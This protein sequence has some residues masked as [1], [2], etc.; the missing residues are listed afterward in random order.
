[1]ASVQKRGANSWLL[2]VEVGIEANGKRIK[3]TK[4]VKANGIREARKLLAEFQT[5]VEAGE[6]VAP[7]KMTLKEFTVNEWQPKYA[8]KKLS[9]TTRRN[10]LDQLNRRILPE[11]GHMRLDQIKTMHLVT[12]FN[13]L[14]EPGSRMD[15]RGDVLSESAVLYIYKV[16]KNVLSR[17]KQWGIILKSPI[18]GVDKPTMENTLRMKRKRKFYDSEEAREIILALL[19]EP[20]KWYLFF[21]GSLLGGF[22]RGELVALEWPRVDF[23]HGGFHIE[24]SIPL[25]ENGNAVVLG[26]K[27]DSEGFVDMPKW[28]MDELQEYYEEW[29]NDRDKAGD[30]WQGGDNE[31]VF[32]GGYGKPY[33]FN[34]P[35][36]TWRRFLK[37]HSFRLLRLHDLRHSTGSILLEEGLTLPVIQNRLRHSKHE[38]TADTYLHVTKKVQRNAADKLE[39][40]DPKN[41]VNNSSTMEDFEQSSPTV[42]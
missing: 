18:D 1:M 17:A 14:K 41:F 20:K 7:A 4:T 12:Y 11:L 8:E 26:P 23:V 39:K 28:Y 10:Y 36:H 37:R 15:G 30:L 19:N 27:A 13:K 31:Y 33:Y 2:V 22:R 5:E 21:L 42:H 9:P 40:F 25:T 6:Y 38:L 35:S 34:T 32:H 16:L 3:R 29:K 24:S